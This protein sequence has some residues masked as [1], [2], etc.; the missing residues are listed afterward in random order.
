VPEVAFD[1]L[2]PGTISGFGTPLADFIL[3]P[4]SGSIDFNIQVTLDP[5]NFLYAQG[6]V[7]DSGF[8][9]MEGTFLHGHESPIPEPGILQLLAIIYLL[10]SLSAMRRK[11]LDLA[12][13]QSG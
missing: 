3:L 7:Y 4:P 2:D 5:G 1:D 8:N 6:D 13:L 12:E 9:E 10:H 11:R